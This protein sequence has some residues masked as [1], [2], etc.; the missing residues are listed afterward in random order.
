MTDP[1]FFG[2][3]SLVNLATHA[4]ADPRPATLRGWRRVWRTTH[5]REAAFLSVDPAPDTAIDGVVARVPGADWAALDAREA[6]YTRHDVT[7]ALAAADP[8]AVYVVSPDYLRHD[9]PGPILLSYL[10]TVAQGFLALHGEAGLARFFATTDGWH[11]P[12]ADDRGAPVYAR[13]TA[14]SPAERRLVD[15]YLARVSGGRETAGTG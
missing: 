10:D 15:R 4:Y 6:A 13:A 2:Y 1:A 5:L 12:V 14:L 7:A 11:H 8:T 9:P 3:G